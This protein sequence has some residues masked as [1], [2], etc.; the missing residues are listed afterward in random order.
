MAS[1]LRIGDQIIASG[2]PTFVIAEAGVNHDGDIDV[3][4]ALVDAAAEAGAQAVKFQTFRADA[5]A[6]ATAPRAAYQERNDPGA[7][8][9]VAML[10]KLELDEAAHR[11]IIERCAERDIVFL[12]TPFDEVSAEMLIALGVPAIKTS[13]GDLTHTAFLRELAAH[14][15]PMLVST[16]MSNEAEVAAAVEAVAGAP[17]AL[18][19]CVSAYPAPDADANLA[20]IPAMAA[21][22]GCPIGWSDH[23]AG[24]AIA[25]AAV[26]LGACVVEKHLTLDC[27]RPGP[28]HAASLEPDAFA[29]LVR[30]LRRVESARGDGVKR[31][32]PSERDTSTVARRSVVTTCAIPA[33]TVINASML[34]CRRPGTGLPP[35]DLERCVG[36]VTRTDL[37]AGTLVG[38]EMFE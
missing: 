33:G 28:D 1:E 17:L 20:A 11:R 25:V 18:L 37:S 23:T 35:S 30:G 29:E 21:R 34:A 19:H 13:S 38:E 26:A 14:G 15:R 8:S 27:R 36:R 7:T 2:A 16:G 24:T 6:T 9:Q 32:M 4:L 22:F 5:L 12:S 31:C 10:E 3:A